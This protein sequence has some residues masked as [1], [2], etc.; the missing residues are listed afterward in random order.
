MASPSFI[1][2]VHQV[3]DAALDLAGIFGLEGSSSAPMASSIAS[4]VEAVHLVAMLF[5]RFLGGVD[6]AFGLVAGL[7]QFLALLVGSAL[8]SASLT[9]FRSRRPTAR[10][11][12][13]W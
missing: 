6:Q 13:G 7:D 5:Q 12:P 11:R 10:P 3:L 9:I 2:G 1:E 8:A 4:T